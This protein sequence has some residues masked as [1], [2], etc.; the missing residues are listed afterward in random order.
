[1][2]SRNKFLI[3][4][5]LLSLLFSISLSAA[6]KDFHVIRENSPHEFYLL[7]NSLRDSITLPEEKARL[8]QYS[9]QINENLG[10][11]AKEHLFLL[12]KT[13]V[14]KGVL[15]YRFDK[16]RQFDINNLLI[17]K[18]ERDYKIKQNKLSGLSRWIWQSIIAELKHRQDL[19]LISEKNFTP[20]SFEA[21]KR[22]QAQRFE[23][24]LYYLIPWID[25][26]DGL[27]PENFNEITKSI[28]WIILDRINQRSLLFRHHASSEFKSD[29]VKIINIPTTVRGPEMQEEKKVET[30]PPS[31]SLSEKAQSEK[32]KAKEKMESITP[33]D[34]SPLSDDVARELEQDSR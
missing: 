20:T 31:P 12:I 24:Y 8:V 14:I 19:G 28:S 2:S 22:T 17:A 25:K 5:T 15:E 4:P 30:T 29:I 23:R 10:K 3:L 18:L 13:E 32:I 26:M 11:L 9:L 27:D 1:L 7:F 6:D 21:D 33:T 34:L 16:V